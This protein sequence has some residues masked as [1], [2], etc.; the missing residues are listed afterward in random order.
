MLN[1][2]NILFVYSMY[3]YR[4][5]F[6]KYSILINDLKSETVKSSLYVIINIVQKRF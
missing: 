4:I 1:L 2:P 3:K 5:W 6:L